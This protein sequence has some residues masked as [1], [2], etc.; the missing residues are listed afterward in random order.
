[1]TRG[2]RR[3]RE[4]AGHRRQRW[5]GAAVRLRTSGVSRS[6]AQ[7]ASRTSKK[8]IGRQAAI[9]QRLG[10]SA[11][12]AAEKQR[13]E[14]R[15]FAAIKSFEVAV[16]YFQKGNYEKAKEIFEKLAGGPTQEVASRAQVYLRM[17][18]QK[19]SRTASEPKAAADLYDLGVAHLNAR[20]LDAAVE[21]LSK[22]LRSG[23]NQDH[24]R[25]ALAAAHAL[26]GNVEAALEHLR[27]AIE[28][29]PAN[30]LLAG[31]DEDFRSLADDPRFQRLIH[32]SV[33][34]A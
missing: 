11:Q 23:P 16:R 31:E 33:A 8:A 27:V 29:R 14:A 17:C 24:V 26:L 22:A 2:S 18:E 9:G 20:N 21:H 32:S 1:M 5:T 13:A 15:Y 19:L 10:S 25:Y 7:L 4:G 6:V 34:Q 3:I 12:E 28:L 30:R